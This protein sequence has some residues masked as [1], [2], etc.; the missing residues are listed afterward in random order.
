MDTEAHTPAKLTPEQIDALLDALRARLRAL[1]GEHLRGVWLFGSYAR[2]DAT[3][4]SD[5]DVAVVLDDAAYESQALARAAS[6]LF[7]E[8]NVEHG[9]PV[10]LAAVRLADLQRNASPLVRNIL[11]EGREVTGAVYHIEEDRGQMSEHIEPLLENSQENIDMARLLFDSNYY[12]G[13]ASRAYY[14]MFYAAQPMLITVNVTPSSHKETQG[15]FGYHFARARR[16]D[17]R[18][19]RMLLDA[20]ETRQ[21][22]DYD[23]TRVVAEAEA[24]AL[25]EQAEGFLAMARA[26]I[27]ANPPGAASIP[28]EG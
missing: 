2:G 17:P 5:I 15:A 18:F 10:S 23:R 13:A 27:A 26:F 19:H 24:R 22:A 1:Y 20:F 8:L 28:G 7:Y 3:R 14:A 6:D 11:R 12:N 16:I 25:I 21:Q 9:A 4:R